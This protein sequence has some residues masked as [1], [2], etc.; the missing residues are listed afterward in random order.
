MLTLYLK[1]TE[2]TK[3]YF[4]GSLNDERKNKQRRDALTIEGL[5]EALHISKSSA[6]QLARSYGFPKLHIGKRI[7]IPIDDLKAW[8]SSKVESQEMGGGII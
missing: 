8:M 3:L 1:S 2:V 4:R 5:A 7:I 6:Y